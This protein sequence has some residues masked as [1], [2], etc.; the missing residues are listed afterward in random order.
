ERASVRPSARLREVLDGQA[1]SAWLQLELLVADERTRVLSPLLVTGRTVAAAPETAEAFIAFAAQ[2][3]PSLELTLVAGGSGGPPPAGPPCPARRRVERPAG[4]RRRGPDPR[5]HAPRRGA[6]APPR[7]AAGPGLARQDR[8]HLDRGLRQRRPPQGERRLGAVRPQARGLPGGGRRRGGDERGR[9]R[10]SG[11][12][13]L[14]AAA[15]GAVRRDQ[16]PDAA[17]RRGPRG[18]PRALADRLPLHRRT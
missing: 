12:L 14:R 10:R 9:A 17:A 13:P 18:H 7:A 3:R 16:R 5:H 4:H 15:G 2:R 11:P 8:A 1:G 6:G